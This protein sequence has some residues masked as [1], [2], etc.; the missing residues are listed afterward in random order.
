M[1]SAFHD[2]L[3]LD[4]VRKAKAAPLTRTSADL[5]TEQLPFCFFYEVIGTA[6]SSTDRSLTFGATFVSTCRPKKASKQCS[7]N[8]QCNNQCDSDNIIL[9]RK[10]K[11]IHHQ[12]SQFSQHL[13]GGA[14]RRR[15]RI[16]R[17]MHLAPGT[18]PTAAAMRSAPAVSP[19][20]THHAFDTSSRM[21]SAGGEA[22]GAA[23]KVPKAATKTNA[24][25]AQLFAYHR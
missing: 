15:G 16:A 25:Y 12:L 6:T 10:G 18:V 17:A 14:R 11:P 1:E 5:Y 20:V 21:R 9:R 13:S 2:A 4:T 22:M 3:A 24:A 7:E 23:C 19:T 8:C